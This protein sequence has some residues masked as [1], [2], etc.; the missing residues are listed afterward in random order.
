MASGPPTDL[1]DALREFDRNAAAQRVAAAREQAEQIRAE[2][3]LGD[4]SSMALE[5][6]ALGHPGYRSSFCYRLE[7]ASPELG[8]IS[9]GSSR[10]LII[11]H[12]ADGSD[13]YF[14]PAYGSVE[15]AWDAL[16]AGFVTAFGLAGEGRF[17]EVDDIPALRSGRALL[18]K[19]LY[20]YFPADLLPIYSQVHVLHFIHKLSGSKPPDLTPIAANRR[21]LEVVRGSSKF[22]GWDP[23]EVMLFLYWWAD[24]RPSR[25]IVKIAPGEGARFWPECRDGG[26]VCVGWD[27]VGDLTAFG[28][29]EEL[30]AVFSQHYPHNGNQSTVTAKARELWR[31]TQLQPGDQVVANEGQSKVLALGTVVDPGYVWRP[32]RGEYRHTVTVRWD[33]A[34]ARTL[35]EPVK[36][37]AVTTVATVPSTL[38][39]RITGERPPKTTGPDLV[40]TSTAASATSATL[41][42][43]PDRQL[44]AVGEALQRK[45]QAILFG[46]PGT[47]KTYTALR[48]AAWWLAPARPGLDP[49][50]EYGTQAFA[51]VLGA[52]SAPPV[53]SAAWWMV[54]NPSEWSWDNLFKDGSVNFRRGKLKTNYTRIRAGDLIFCYEASPVKRIV[55]FAQV[56]QVNLDRTEPVTLRP[57]S[58]VIDGPTWAQISE[59]P[60]L[61]AS[62]P[63]TNRSQGTLFALTADEAHRLADLTAETDSDIDAAV[64]GRREVGLLT[65]VTFHPSY[66]YED[67]IE[68]FKPFPSPTGGLNLRLVDGIFKRVC[69]TA[70][71]DP[72]KPY[73]VVVDEINRGNIPKIFGELITLL[74]SDKRGLEVRLPQSGEAFAVPANVYVLGT[75]NTA[76]RSIRLLD[77]ALRRRFAFHELLPDDELL[78]GAYVGKLHLADLL[79]TLN[80][81]VR[82]EI[83]RDRQIGHA[84]LLR[85]GRPVAT[86]E[87]L[88]A[89]IR[90]DVIPL[91]QEY[92]YDDYG[93]LGRLLGAGTVDV[94][95]QHLRD[96]TDSDLV[97]ALYTEFQATVTD[98]SLP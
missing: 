52:L 9:G 94:T 43:A 98:Q 76:D 95:S 5:R 33:E 51:E 23:M 7:F 12:R 30:R 42:A 16:R 14:D 55:G 89:A 96:L 39:K 77:A 58:R 21:L 35:S 45:G 74:E 11:Y 97:E 15:T 13:W 86:E 37:W 49:S 3:P 79:S 36:R 29:E 47:G 6:Y 66:G 44:Q 54:A 70:L 62:E 41:L 93:L 22:A 83:G 61:A 81:R 31:L 19:S 18:S 24:P 59:D 4:W 27:D 69:R 84:F 71:T 46:P 34:A 32:D 2:F 28:S 40:A 80:D 72:Q 25:A 20:V 64:A 53:G 90:A 50:V 91:L 38:W 10:K 73:L 17:A 88:A 57:V 67:F 85:D 26:Y 1:D 82:T 63:V 48:F 56:A 92:A 8:S 68:G 75:M 65:Q 60:R 78:E 87:D